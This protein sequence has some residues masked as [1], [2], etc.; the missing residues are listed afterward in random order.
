VDARVTP[1][2]TAADR[3]NA[4]GWRL[5][6]RQRGSMC[7]ADVRRSLA[8]T[9]DLVGEGNRDGDAMPRVGRADLGDRRWGDEIRALGVRRLEDREAAGRFRK[10][11]P[12]PSSL[13]SGMVGGNVPSAY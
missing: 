2:L 12:E 9:C 7:L 11:R 4:A 3:T 5:Y 10:I 8:A 1:G 6:R 13:R